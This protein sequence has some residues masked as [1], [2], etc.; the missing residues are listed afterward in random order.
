M[1]ATSTLQTFQLGEGLCR[2][3]YDLITGDEKVDGGLWSEWGETLLVRIV[4]K[5][6]VPADINGIAN[7]ASQKFGALNHAAQSG[8]RPV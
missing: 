8:P 6:R 2:E 5:Y 7:D 4:H 1:V 3:N